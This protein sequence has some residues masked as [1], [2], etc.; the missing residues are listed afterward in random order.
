MIRRPAVVTKIEP[1]IDNLVEYLESSASPPRM[2][3][4]ITSEMPV[5]PT[6]CILYN[7]EQLTRAT[8]LQRIL[9]R[10]QCEDV[11]EVW[12]YSLANIN[13]L[14]QHGVNAVHCPVAAAPSHLERI[15]AL[16]VG[17]PMYDVGFAGTPSQRRL[18]V[19]DA[20]VQAGLSV[21]LIMDKIGDAR[22][23][24]LAKCRVIINI[25]FAEDYQ[26]FESVRCA[27]WL[28]IGKPV[29]SEQSI[30]DDPRAVNVPYVDLVSAT[31]LAVEKSGNL[32]HVLHEGAERL[33]HTN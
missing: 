27:P 16:S 24:V 26:V 7:T 32:V 9:T 10:A 31:L 23:A 3:P 29:V 33:Q 1:Y 14:A 11:A 13:I 6:K 30:D 17:E 12:D 8:E 25:H 21:C 4:L 18:A 28:C 20:L 5:M 19:L 2:L 15:Q 22:D